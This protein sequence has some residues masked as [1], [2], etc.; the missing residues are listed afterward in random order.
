MSSRGLWEPEQRRS[1]RAACQG[2]K[3]SSTSSD[4]PLI[5]SRKEGSFRKGSKQS[6]RE[7]QS[8]PSSPPSHSSPSH[9]NP[10]EPLGT[11]G[12]GALPEPTQQ[13]LWAFDLRC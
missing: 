10:G 6:S 11:A 3:S 2:W 7:R 9:L 4:H 1:Q 13:S 5:L 8:W 12:A